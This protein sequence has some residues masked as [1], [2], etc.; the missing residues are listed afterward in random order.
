VGREEGGGGESVTTTTSWKE[1]YRPWTNLN[2]Y[3]D[4]NPN[5]VGVTF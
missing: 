4:K 5:L 2:W 3:H 1:A